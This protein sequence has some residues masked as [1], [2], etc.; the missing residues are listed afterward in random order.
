MMEIEQMAEVCHEA[1]RAYC[2]SLGDTSHKPWKETAWSIKQSAIA[3][4][5]F[6]QEKPDAPLNFLHENW[7][8]RKAAEGWFFGETKDEEKKTHPCNG[9]YTRRYVYS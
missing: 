7:R 9:R 6:L 2:L 4:V 1:N 3:G 5:V 8:K